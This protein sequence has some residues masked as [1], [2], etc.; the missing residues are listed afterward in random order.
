MAH[1]SHYDLPRSMKAHVLEKFNTPYVL[2]EVALP[3]IEDQH[4]M[5]IRVDAASYCHTDAV[6]AS[7]QLGPESMLPHV[8][9]HEFAGTVVALGSDVVSYQVGDRVAVPGRGYHVCGKCMECLNPSGLDADEPGFSVYCPYVERGLGVGAGRHGGFREYALVDSRQVAGIPEGMTAVEVAPL[10][11]AGL[12]VYSALRKC[13][14]KPGQRVGIMG[15]GG[16]LGHLGVQFA[17]KM[18]LIVTGVDVA[19]GA[20]ELAREV[21][22]GMGARIVDARSEKAGD[23]RRRMGEEDGRG[24]LAEMGVDA[25]LILPESQM[26][27][28]YGVG[29]VRNGGIVVVVSFPSDGFHV[30]ASDLVFRRI[31]V[32]G[33]LIGSNKAMRDMFEFCER[34]RTYPFEKLNELVEDY[35]KGVAGKLVL[36]M[37]MEE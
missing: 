17:V 33:S 24:H 19:P 2:R 37:G 32:V 14:L 10:M 13:E 34:V 4:D 26:A 11:C 29:L 15:C 6:L 36:D 8:G 5:L 25:V 20:L 22:T 21:G 7:G 35:H 12:T 27:F 31:R 9:C 18:G 1:T 28:D 23:V 30:A 16:G 3:S